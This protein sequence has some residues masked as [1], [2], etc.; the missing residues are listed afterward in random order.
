SHARLLYPDKRSEA[1]KDDR[2][3]R[4]FSARAQSALSRSCNINSS[5]SGGRVLSLKTHFGLITPPFHSI[6][7]FG[8]A[9]ASSSTP[10]AVTLVSLNF[11]MVNLSSPVRWAS[12]ASLTCV[13][14]RW[15]VVRFLQSLK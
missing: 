3:V 1:G 13:R 15:R 8:N 14:C 6:M 4:D 2:I 7:H 11:S 9:F 10:L 12:P 5:E